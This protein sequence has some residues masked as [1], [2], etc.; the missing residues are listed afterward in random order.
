MPSTNVIQHTLNLKMAVNN[1][2]IQDHAQPTYKMTPP[3]FKP[4]IKFRHS[5]KEKQTLVF[6]R[7]GGARQEV[8]VTNLIS[9]NLHVRRI[10][11]GAQDKRCTQER[12]K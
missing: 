12:R 1:S 7:K 8:E 2:P 10:R 4:L 9:R 3:M 11:I 6:F 5:L